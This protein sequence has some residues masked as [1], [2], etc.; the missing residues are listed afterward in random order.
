MTDETKITGCGGRT[1]CKNQPTPETHPCPY[2]ED[3]NN[4]PSDHCNCCDAC[5]Q[6]CCDDI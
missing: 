3:V 2:Q 1:G 4:D 5:Q 6:E